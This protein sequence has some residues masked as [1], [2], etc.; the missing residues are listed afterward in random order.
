MGL[1]L[2]LISREG[3][4]GDGVD[5]LEDAL[6]NVWTVLFEV[7]EQG[8]DLLPLRAAFSRLA[9]GAVLREAAGTLDKVQLVVPPPGDDVL[10]MD[11]IHGTN[12]LHSREIGAVKLG[13]HGLELGAIEHSHYSSFNDVIEMVP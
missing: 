9:A 7:M 10:F 4:Q 2:A 5:G 6:F 12:Q 1:T 3:V 8:F 11:T 13:E